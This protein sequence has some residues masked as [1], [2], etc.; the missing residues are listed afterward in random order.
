LTRRLQRSI[1][2]ELD[3]VALEAQGLPPSA[4]DHTP[5]G[6]LGEG[7]QA[8][9]AGLAEGLRAS[10]FQLAAWKLNP[11]AVNYLR[12]SSSNHACSVGRGRDRAGHATG[13][14]V[15]SGV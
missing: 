9:P 12:G 3:A 5:R 11:F 8:P 4:R 6:C 1:A 2:V 13:D 10:A 7:L 15:A 14:G